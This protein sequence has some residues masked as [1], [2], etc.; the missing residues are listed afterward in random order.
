MAKGAK[1]FHGCK[2]SGEERR[3]RIVNWLRFLFERLRIVVAELVQVQRIEPTRHV[4]EC[5]RL[6]R[7][8][9]N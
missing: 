8:Y 5:G 2:L 6:L 7:L 1:I 9:G 4:F 3:S